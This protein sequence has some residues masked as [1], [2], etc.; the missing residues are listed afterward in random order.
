MGPKL[1][2]AA[3]VA[4]TGGRG[5][6]GAGGAGRGQG[7]HASPKFVGPV[8]RQRQ[9]TLGDLLGERF[10]RTPGPATAAD[11]DIQETMVSWNYEVK[12]DDGNHVAYLHQEQ[13]I[14]GLVEYAMEK[15]KRTTLLAK[16]CEDYYV[17]KDDAEEK[18]DV[19]SSGPRGAARA[20]HSRRRCGHGC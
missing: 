15:E 9:P 7:R 14:G 6:R 16:G 4:R 5:G 1:A 12:D 18:V 8:M 17:N 19:A 3:A 11:D 20:A 2:N 13:R 10:K